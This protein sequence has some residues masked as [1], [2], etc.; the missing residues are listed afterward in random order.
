MIVFEPTPFGA[1]PGH[2]DPGDRARPL[3]P[4]LRAACVAYG[5]AEANL[6][7]LFAGNA[8]CVTTGQQPGLFTGPLFTIYKAL[9]A[10]ALA[11]VLAD[12]LGRAVVPVFWVAGDD[13]DFAEANHVHLLAVSN[14]VRAVTLRE[15]DPAA[16]LTPL[17][18][19]PVGREIGQALEAVSGTV[20]ETEFR[21]AVLAWLERYYGPETDLAT[22]F[23]RALADLLGDYGVV[24]F[25]PTH[26][27]VKQA[28]APLLLALLE[29]ADELDRTLLAR[30][31]QLERQ[32]RAAPVAVGEGASTVLLEASLGRD[33]LMLQD[34]AFVARRAGERWTQQELARLAREAPERFS[35]NVLARPVI[36][37]ALLPTVAYVAG[38]GELAY[39]PQAEP[40]YRAL[41]VSP[42]TPVPRWSGRIIEARVA[43]VLEK[44]GI[45]ADALTGPEGQLEAALVRDEMPR[46][47]RQAL[48]ALRATIEAEYHRLSEAAV[49]IDPTLRKPVESAKHAALAGAAEIE[50]RLVSHLKQHNEI[51]VTQLAKA[52][53]NLFPLGRPQER[54]LNVVPYL[55]RYGRDFLTR[56]DAACEAHAR[57][58][59]TAMG[60]P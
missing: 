33:R 9:S 27:A 30:V 21:P 43:K 48:A 17:Y 32:G 47:A 18:R 28:M 50:K 13:H 45:A 22:A 1:P 15:R 49:T 41:D 40:L 7:R 19:E 5:A 57:A 29:Q 12:R 44:Y 60:D 39:L 53:Q 25:Q 11:R 46:E 24:V 56:A 37:G 16:P 51:L 52:R 35:P 6:D 10:A 20:P 26:P 14:E 23:T 54:V 31:R 3:D 42:Q 59:A 38:P 55:V 2:L 36:E 58:L 4:A 8:L 34:G